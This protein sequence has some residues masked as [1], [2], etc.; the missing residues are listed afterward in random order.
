MHSWG[1]FRDTWEAYLRMFK[2]DEDWCLE[3]NLVKL[4]VLFTM[5]SRGQSA[6]KKQDTFNNFPKEEL[7]DQ[8]PDE[9]MDGQPNIIR[10]E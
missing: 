2:A 5:R 8:K 4:I 1:F 3:I 10:D 9:A 6:K 7:K